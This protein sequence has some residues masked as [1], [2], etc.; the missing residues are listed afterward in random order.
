MLI[1]YVLILGI[2]VGER[3][4]GRE[5]KVINDGKK[6]WAYPGIEPGTSRTLSENHTTRP[7]GLCHFYRSLG[8]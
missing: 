5:K 3:V 8:I 4:H 7:A 2:I 1:E 6:R